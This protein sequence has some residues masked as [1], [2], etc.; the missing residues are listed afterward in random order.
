VRAMGCGRVMSPVV[1]DRTDPYGVMIVTMGRTMTAQAVSRFSRGIPPPA[2]V[3]WRRPP[4]SYRAR[5]NRPAVKD[6]EFAQPCLTGPTD[7]RMALQNPHAIDDHLDRR[8]E[9][10]AVIYRCTSAAANTSPRCSCVRV[11]ATPR[12][13][14]DPDP[15]KDRYSRLSRGASHFEHD[16]DPRTPHPARRELQSLRP[17]QTR[18]D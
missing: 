10:C 13:A 5:H 3:G 8:D 15:K 11:H 4:H 6:H 9:G 17:V 14:C 12:R 16:K 2:D 1:P 18:P 7:E